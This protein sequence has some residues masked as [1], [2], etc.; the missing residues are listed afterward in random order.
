[1]GVLDGDPGHVADGDGA[2]VAGEVGV[3]LKAAADTREATEPE[4]EDGGGGV[5]CEVGLGGGQ[6]GNSGHHHPTALRGIV[7]LDTAAAQQSRRVLAAVDPASLAGGTEGE[8]SR[9]Q[10]KKKGK[11]LREIEK[12]P[13]PSA[14]EALASGVCPWYSST[15]CH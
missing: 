14:T 3:V 9:K 13:T 5:G 1:M 8:N 6:A 7:T 4:G 10:K 15:S 2:S 11:L 12:I